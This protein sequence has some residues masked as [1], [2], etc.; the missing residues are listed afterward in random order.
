MKLERTPISFITYMC[1]YLLLMEWLIPLPEISNTGYISFFAFVTAFFFLIVFLDLPWWVTW[2]LIGL[3]IITVLH[4]IFYDEI[5]FSLAWWQLFIEDIFLHIGFLV[6]GTWGETSHS[7]QSFMFLLLLVMM[8]YLLYFWIAYAKRILFFFICTVIFIGVLDTFFSY[9]GSM[10]IVRVTVIGFLLLLLLQWS[11]MITY[12]PFRDSRKAFIRWFV[13]S[14]LFLGTAVSVAHFLPKSGPAWDDPIPYVQQFLGIDDEHGLFLHQEARRVGYGSDDSQLGGGFQQDHRLVFTAV[15]DKE[16][17]YWRGESKNVYTGHGW[18]TNTPLEFVS[19]G[20]FYESDVE[21]YENKVDMYLEKEMRYDFVF[22]DGSLKE[23]RVPGDEV[24]I[25]IDS[26]TGKAYQH[27]N[28]QPFV[29][30]FYETVVRSPLLLQEDLRGSNGDDPAYIR[31]YF[32][33][34]PEHLSPDVKALAQSLTEEEETRYDKVRAIE[35]FFHSP[36]FTYETENV[37]V[38]QEG[39]DYVEQFLFETK[40]GYCDN[41][42]TSMV[43]LLR[44]IGIPAR[45]VKG[46]TS[47]EQVGME[48]ERIVYEVTNGNAHSWVEVYFPSV[49]WVPFEPTKGFSTESFYSIETDEREEKEEIV[50]ETEEEVK[51]EIEEIAEDSRNLEEPSRK[52][53][54]FFL[55]PLL[56][57]GIIYKYRLPIYKKIVLSHYRRISDET[58]FAKAYVA[59]IILLKLAGH[60][61]KK[62]ETLREFA[63]RLDEKYDMKEMSMLTE[64]YEQIHYGNKKSLSLSPKTYGAWVKIVKRIES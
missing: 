58:E 11:R 57:I 38:P 4:F 28:G 59:L 32:L 56:F 19:E 46:F 17:R 47:G 62:S 63:L 41:F 44:S 24:D 31:E 10:A 7:F 14:F 9:D 12:F 37:P 53:L 27:I 21:T 20:S 45:W 50:E 51:E 3:T 55:L 54:L 16:V 22:Y 25:A 64:Q 15:A 48:E 35:A 49:G 34:L 26:Y 29:S 61:R 33:Q 5:F 36:E 23:F 1:G 2:S 13:V 42:S 18:E 60:T 52:W 40:R 8:S 6:S 43:V 39:E 30:F